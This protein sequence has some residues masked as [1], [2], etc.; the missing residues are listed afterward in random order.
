MLLIFIFWSACA[1]H[2]KRIRNGNAAAVW[3]QSSLAVS[4]PE[5]WRC[6]IC[7]NRQ[8]GDQKIP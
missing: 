8:T 2:G 3:C 5:K 1:P 4:L 7:S 6:R